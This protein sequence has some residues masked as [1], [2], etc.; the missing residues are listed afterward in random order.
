MNKPRKYCKAYPCSNLA[1]PGSAY[2]AEHKPAAPTKE[3][4][5]FYLSVQ[6]RRFR[7]FYI[8]KHP[9][10]EQ[11][12]REG[13]LT[14]AATIDHIV[15]LKD[16][17]KRLAEENAMALCWKCHA[18]KTADER[19]KRKNHQESCGNNRMSSQIVSKF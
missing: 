7:N 17:G 16:G 1:E 4:D 6:W 15:E 3:T 10:C 18:R 13:R 5:P 9:L 11:C 19:S 12:E 14:L 8:G 2:C